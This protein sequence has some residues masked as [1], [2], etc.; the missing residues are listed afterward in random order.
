MPERLTT[1]EEIFSFK[2]GAALT[3]EKTILGMLE[4]LEQN[5]QREELKE[6][7]SEHAAETTQHVANIEKSFA[8]LGEEAKPSPCPA[9][10]GLKEE[11]TSAIAMTDNSIVDAVLLAGAGE[12]EHHEIGVYETLVTNAEARGAAD[13]AELL[14]QNL[15]QE[16][17]A[18][19]KVKTMG[20]KISTEGIAVTA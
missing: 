13:V 16:Q 12:T 5:A 9:I 4:D 1:P 11:G 20:K 14:K 3:M 7:F 2:L 15:Q 10:D 17:A 8:L 18:L 19:E 6:L